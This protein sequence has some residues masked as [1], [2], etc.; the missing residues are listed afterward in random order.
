M[1]GVLVLV[2]ALLYLLVSRELWRLNR[3]ASCW[4]ALVFIASS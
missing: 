3:R 1:T 4:A 2:I